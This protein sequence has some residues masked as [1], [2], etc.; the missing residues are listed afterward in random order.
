VEAVAAVVPPTFHVDMDPNATWQTAANA[1]PLMKR[2]EKY[3]IVAVF[4]SPIPQDDILG[5]RQIRQAVSR[6]IAMH[7]GS[8]P[9]TTVIREEVCD[10]FVIGGGKSAVMRQ[11]QLAAEANM[12]FW[13]QLVGNGLTT[14]WDAHLGGVLTHAT[15]PAISCMNLY[16]HQLLTEPIAVVDGNQRVPDGPGL[17]VEVDEA[18]VEAHRVPDDLLAAAAAKGEPYSPPMPRQIS[19]I[20]YPDENCV[21]TAGGATLPGR[22]VEG[23]RTETWM[24][25]GTRAWADLWERLQDGPVR[26]PWQGHG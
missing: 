26:E 3:D 22:Y 21:H 9:Y 7:Y 6:P 11:G 14:T 25:D 17:G 10:G 13:L 24:E 5:N 8:P 16:T 4:E 1:I 2:L 12:P 15:W 18:A 20:I 23:I 19:S